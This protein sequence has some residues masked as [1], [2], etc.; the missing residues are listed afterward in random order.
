MEGNKNKDS[1]RHVWRRVLTLCLLIMAM[2]LMGPQGA[3]YASGEGTVSLHIFKIWDGA[4]RAVAVCRYLDADT[5][6]TLQ[7]DDALIRRVGEGYMFSDPAIEGY[8]FIGLAPDSD[9]AEGIMGS[10][11]AMVTML[12]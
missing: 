3:A 4:K 12:Y 7:S 2:A 9:P 10:N 1:V 8:H 5:G 6:E 11:G